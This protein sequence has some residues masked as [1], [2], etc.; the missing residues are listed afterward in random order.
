MA[1]ILVRPV[2]AEELL[3]VNEIRAYVNQVHVQGRPDIFRPGFCKELEQH[4]YDVMQRPNWNVF[5]A[6]L[7]GE[8]CGFA[9]VEYL[10]KPESPYNLA[11][12]MYHVEEF[13]VH[14]AFH[15]RGAATALMEYMKQDAVERGFTKLELD[16]WEFNEGAL[17]FYESV[18]FTTYRR[19]M[20]LKL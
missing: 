12:K 16:M 6:V 4:L 1:E 18:G 3:R 13:G 20:E 7:D 9:T 19:Y 17:A 10:E 5:V 8:I 11:R 15:R 2:E 14:P